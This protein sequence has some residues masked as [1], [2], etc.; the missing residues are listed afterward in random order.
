MIAFDVAHAS[1]FAIYMAVTNKVC[2][3][4][5]S[6]H[7]TPLSGSSRERCWRPSAARDSSFGRKASL[8]QQILVRWSCW[9]ARKRQCR[10]TPRL[11]LVDDKT[12][13]RKTRGLL[14]PASDSLATLH[15][16]PVGGY[17]VKSKARSLCFALVA[18]GSGRHDRCQGAFATADPQIK[19]RSR[20][21]S[22]GLSRTIHVR[23][24]GESGL[25]RW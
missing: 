24:C 12:T 19:G 20:R 16:T 14:Q 4:S 21:R 10:Q 11:S 13:S 9:G 23:V 25:D 8:G 18:Q 15:S 6:R 3:E 1:V 2:G 17:K 5:D 7:D 22:R